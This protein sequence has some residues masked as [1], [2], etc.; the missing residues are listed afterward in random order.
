MLTVALVESPSPAAER[1]RVGLP[2]QADRRS[3]RYSSLR[4]TNE[5]SRLQLRAMAALARE[6]GIGVEL[7]RA[8]AGRARGADGAVARGRVDRRPAAGGRRP[9]LRC[10]PGGPVACAD[11]EVVI[12][13]DGTATMEFARQWVAGEHLARWHRQASRAI[14]SRSH[15]SLA[16]RSPPSVRRRIGPGSRAGSPSSAACRSIGRRRRWSQH[17]RLDPSSVPAPRRQAGGRPRRHLAGGDR[18]RGR[19]RPTWWVARCWRKHGVDRYFAHRKE[20]DVKLERIRSGLQIVRP[21]LPL[22]IAAERRDRRPSDQLPL[23]PR[24]HPAPVAGRH[25]AEVLVC[26]IGEEWLTPSRGRSVPSCA[27]STRP[28]AI[29]SGLPPSP[30]DANSMPGPGFTWRSQECT[31]PSVALCGILRR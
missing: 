29:D 1:R 9:L 22:E 18:R 14:A 10:H 3:S 31:F 21:E 8:A 20:S 23:D 28:P 4:P 19:R 25:R 2:G 17:V 5:R 7:A 24:P 6:T 12:V 27:R 30:A 11:A 26:D 13:D 15:D 16:T